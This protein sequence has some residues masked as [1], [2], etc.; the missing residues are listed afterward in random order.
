M[1]Y[2]EKTIYRILLTPVFMAFILFTAN[3]SAQSRSLDEIRMTLEAASEKQVQEK[4]YIHTDNMCYF[5]G[6]TLWYKAYVVRADNL[7]FTDMSRIL[8]VELI[9]PDGMLVERQHII[10]SD[11]GFSCGNFHIPDS[12]YSGYYELRAYTKWMLNF[13][14][15]THRFSKEDAYLF[16]NNEMAADYFRQWDGLYSRVFPIYTRPEEPGNYTYK[17]MSGRPKQHIMKAAKRKL[18]ATFFPEGGTLVEGVTNRVAFELTDQNGAAVNISGTVRNT[19]GDVTKIQTQHMGRGSF[20]VTPGSEKLKATF[21]WKDE[22]YS[23]DLPEAVTSGAA[24]MLKGNTME[25]YARNLPD[26][27]QYA[28]SVICRGV[29]KHF[30]AITF[31]N[32]GKATVSIPQLPTGVNDITLFDNDGHIVADRLFFVN[33]HDYD[34][35]TVSI[36]N[37][38]KK[39]Y[40]PYE[41]INLGL[42]CNGIDTPTLLSVAVRD[43]ETDDDTYDNGDIMTDLL[44][45]SE[46]KGFI[47]NPKYYV[48]SDDEQHREALY[49]LMLVQGWRKYKWQELSDTTLMVRRY[50]PEKSMTIEGRVYKMLSLEPTEPEEIRMWRLGK[51]MIGKLDG[52]EITEEAAETTATKTSINDEIL[53]IEYDKI[54]LANAHLGVNHK[55]MKK[56]VTVEAEIIFPDAVVGSAQQTHD[57]G[58]FVFEVPPYYGDAILNM[59]AYNNKDSLRKGMTTSIDRQARNELAYPDFYVK[60]DLFFPVFTEKY[61]Y[62]QTHL[63]ELR[64]SLDIGNDSLWGIGNEDHMLSNVDVTTKRRGKR[65]IDY[66]KPTYVCN[67]YDMYNT[68]TD[69]GLSY[70]MLDMRQF[71]VQAA[72][73]LY[74]N[75]G[76]YNRFNVDG[77]LDNFVYYRNYT[78]E[79]ERIH[80]SA[81]TIT[82]Y[83]IYERLKLKSMKTLR[84][85]TDYE[86]RNEDAPM[87]ISVVEPDATVQIIPTEDPGEQ[88]SMRDRH[89]ILHGFNEPAEFYSP[90]YLN[91]QPE[92]PTDYRRTLY[93]NANA[94]TDAEGN[95]NLSFFNNSKETK[96]KISAAGITHDGRLIRMK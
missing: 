92:S 25:I 24:M 82:V 87:E 34:Y 63:P 39:K 50:Q 18:I 23:F 40:A 46:L 96:I 44:L 49:L 66:T 91:W 81:P 47:A 57:K 33:N 84:F 79:E 89:I 35:S 69:Y 74:G 95:L 80:D 6:D 26:D 5:T 10:V 22:E 31:G 11:R 67:A 59:K 62:Y 16:Y 15:T 72:R 64:T 19:N 86:P 29:L 65:G 2:S 21:K 13:N 73:F 60:R 54:H 38:T 76:R 51:G 85:F 12:I 94:K 56:E 28:I 45:C 88:I 37:D 83:Y 78:P 1:T 53:R 55:P 68:I 61:N 77:R 32:D 30:S 71:P 90:D 52:S 8:Y 41:Q 3:A 75:M 42:H 14:S 48:E 43:S 17:Q 70:G 9:S 7:T 4:V 36:E 58:R 27:R 20:T 93:W